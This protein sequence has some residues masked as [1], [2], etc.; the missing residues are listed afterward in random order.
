MIIGRRLLNLATAVTVSVTAVLVSAGTLAEAQADSAAPWIGKPIDVIA[1]G[2][3]YTAGNGANSDQG[4]DAY[5]SIGCHRS[6][7]NYAKIFYDSISSN[8]WYDNR[9][10]GGDVLDDIPGQL[11]FLTDQ[12]KQQA[13]IVFVSVGGNDAKFS[14]IVAACW[15]VKSI[16]QS[17]G[18]KVEFARNN[19]DAG[20]AI[21]SRTRAALEAIATSIPNAHVVFVGYPE[22][23]D[24]TIPEGVSEADSY[25]FYRDEY[26]ARQTNAILATHANSVKGHIEAL[27]GTEQFAGRFSFF[28]RRPLFETHEVGGSGENW[29]YPITGTIDNDERYHP[30]PV[31]WRQTGYALADPVGV[32]RPALETLADV[33]E[34]IGTRAPGT[35][36]KVPDRL[37]SWL[38]QDDLTLR[39]IPDGGTFEC[40]EAQGH[41]VMLITEAELSLL[42]EEGDP[43]QAFCFT[44]DTAR[45]SIAI[46][47]SGTAW[48][49]RNNG[50]GDL[51]RVEIPSEAAFRCLL[52]Q[53]FTILPV[54]RDGEIHSI[55]THEH[56]GGLRLPTPHCIDP[57]EIGDGLI[58][59]ATDSDDSFLVSAS[60][61]GELQ[62]RR[63]TD[64]DTFGCV[65]ATYPVNNDGFT[66]RDLTES[67]EKADDVDRCLPFW[68]YDGQ[69]L[70]HDGTQVLI[71]SNGQ[72]GVRDGA[73]SRCLTDWQ[74]TTVVSVDAEMFASVPADPAGWATCD[75]GVAD[76]TVVRNQDT[77]WTGRKYTG[78]DGAAFLAH[79]ETSETFR[80]LE[81]QGAARLDVTSEQIEAFVIGETPEAPC[82][83]PN[84]YKGQILT[85]TDGIT[86]YYVDPTTAKL[87]AIANGGT[88][89]C[90][91]LWSSA[92][93]NAE[94][95]TEA[96]LAEFEPG[97]TATCRAHVDQAANKIV[98]A[99]EGG[100]SIYVD[101]NGNAHNIETANAYACLIEQGA[102]VKNVPNHD[103][104]Q[105][106]SYGAN[107]PG[108]N[109]IL[110][111]ET[112]TSYRELSDGRVLSIADT[113]SYYCHADPLPAYRIVSVS[114]ATVNAMGVDGTATKCLSPSRYE[115]KIVR[116][117][118]GRAGIVFSGKWRL[119]RDGHSWACYRD[120]GYEIGEYSTSATHLNS[121]PK[122]TALN[123]CLRKSSY[124]N[125]LI[126][127]KGG[128][129]YKTSS[130]GCAYHVGNGWTLEALRDDRKI[131]IA[132]RN[133]TNQHVDSLG[134]CGTH[135]WMFSTKSFKH[136]IIRRKSSGAIYFVN[137]AGCRYH[138]ATWPTYLARRSQGYK[139][140]HWNASDSEIFSLKYCGKQRDFLHKPMV[141][142]HVVRG[143][144][145]TS[146]LVINGEWKWIR[147][148]S[149]WNHLVDKCGLA[150]ST[151][152]YS[153]THIDSIKYDRS[154]WAS[155]WDYRNC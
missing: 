35:I 2:D 149:Y 129:W 142:G 36:V 111:T 75:T 91:N 19:L 50:P 79:I 30:T 140:Q 112:G 115:G 103:W 60:P 110:T 48:L 138:I 109:K 118:S 82:L 86:S 150:P 62:R 120:R 154:H 139:V 137:S 6:A 136:K 7:A 13:D 33:D 9:A 80:C 5:D 122:G 78:P 90:L 77:G 134:R 74:N 49:F 126:E 59:S 10:C 116:D 29:I 22:L 100:H 93:V 94:T 69:I 67:T 121:I 44:E 151:Y 12:Q 15:S 133:L 18:D 155:W 84:T 61:D 124:K 95:W 114:Q 11:H 45:D 119:I 76:G 31:G 65:A 54:V 21:L 71:T 64:T 68:E 123:Y 143:P 127:V 70:E 144:D 27:N 26:W 8:G 47:S 3:S 96:Q 58:I 152:S 117:S 4:W 24:D 88:Y 23:H 98:T 106:F 41:P 56:N 108:C 14:E 66:A 25:E 32:M 52:A 73:T 51:T 145:G 89:L 34:E 105:A 135:S 83:D 72:R 63:I 42:G 141:E 55:P 37:D 146:W 57:G 132:A 128:H 16:W 17:C 107:Q 53:H 148:G 153:W 101:S 97:T 28:D 81:G 40:L 113:Q 102:A 1:L 130:S 20:E 85:A 131:S 87:R 147:N 39:P 99:T 43:A 125:K 92:P 46:D 38:V 104:Q